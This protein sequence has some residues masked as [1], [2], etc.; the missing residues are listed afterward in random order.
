MFVLLQTFIK[1]HA[2]RSQMSFD[3]YNTNKKKSPLKIKK[4]LINEKTKVC[5]ELLGKIEMITNNN[6]IT[7]S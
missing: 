1:M 3:L 6:V 2:L 4:P 5:T 7:A